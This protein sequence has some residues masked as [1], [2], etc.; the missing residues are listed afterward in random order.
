MLGHQHTLCGQGLKKVHTTSTSTHK[1]NPGGFHY[2]NMHRRIAS[3]TFR[4]LRP[5]L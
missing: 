2:R 3:W 1:A 4:G 5:N